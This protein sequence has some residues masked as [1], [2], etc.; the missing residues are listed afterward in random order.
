MFQRNAA[1]IGFLFVFCVIVFSFPSVN[2]GKPAIADQP[3][4][5]TLTRYDCLPMNFYCQR[6]Q[7]TNSD[8][9]MYNKVCTKSKSPL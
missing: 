2:R 4:G 1:T 3:F 5:E 7:R 6:L 9:V 8:K